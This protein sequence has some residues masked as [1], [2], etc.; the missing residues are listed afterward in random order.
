M[1]KI[2]SRIAILLGGLLYLGLLG[3][4]IAG[5][6]AVNNPTP[7]KVEQGLRLDSGNPDIWVHSARQRHFSVSTPEADQAVEGYKNAIMRNPI[8]S[9]TWRDL[10]TAYMESDDLDEAEVTLRGELQVAPQ[11]PEI[12]WR[13]ANFLLVGGR[14]GEAYPYLRRAASEPTL[15]VAVFDLAHRLEASP[16]VIR[17]QLVPET[18]EARLSYLAFLVARRNLAEAYP[19]WRD[20]AGNWSPENL[21]VA[22]LYVDSLAQ[23]GMGQDAGKVWGELLALTNRSGLR[24][25]GEFLTNADFEARISNAGLDWRFIEGEGYKIALDSFTFQSGTQSLRVTFDGT[26][27]VNFTGI[28]QLIPVEPNRQY[29]FEGFLKTEGITTDSGLFFT[30]VPQAAPREEY[31][32]VHTGKHVETFGWIHEQL[33]FSTGPNTSVVAVQLR[34]LPSQKLNNLIQGKVWIDHLSLKRRDR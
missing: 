25:E 26:A 16:E 2:L 22:N 4:S 30:L 19:V 9:A 17:E 1:R 5:K 34:R 14:T 6:R 7:E 28:Y 15:R 8:N 31:F 20:V 29:R 3:V 33:D 13:M 24:K 10:T 21:R 11:N 27:N 12:A 18:P 32:E 23:A